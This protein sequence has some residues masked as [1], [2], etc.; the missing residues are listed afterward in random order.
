MW[1]R[2]RGHMWLMERDV[3]KNKGTYVADGERCG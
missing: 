2:I 3:A 1:L